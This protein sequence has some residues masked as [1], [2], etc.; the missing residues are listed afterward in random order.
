M[1]QPLKQTPSEYKFKNITATPTCSML[2]NL[3]CIEE[4]WQFHS[5]F[6]PPTCTDNQKLHAAFIQHLLFSVPMQEY[7]NTNKFKKSYPKEMA[8][9]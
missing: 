9:P 8:V 4:S 3:C 2:I 1:D 7:L 6:S 5:S